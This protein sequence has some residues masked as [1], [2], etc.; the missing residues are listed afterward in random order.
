MLGCSEC[1]IYQ[2][3]NCPGFLSR[4]LS[5]MHKQMSGVLTWQQIAAAIMLCS[6][7]IRRVKISYRFFIIDLIILGSFGHN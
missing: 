1:V 5:M 3:A 7:Y 6:H 2:V 4:G